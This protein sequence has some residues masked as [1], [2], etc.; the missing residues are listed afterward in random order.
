MC[1]GN[2]GNHV[3]GE[4]RDRE[5]FFDALDEAVERTGWLIHAYV[6]MGTHW[7]ALLETPEPNLSEGM[8]WFQ[9][10]FTQRY[11]SDHRT[12]GHVYQGRFKAIVVD[13]TDA[14]YFRTA[15][16]YIHLNP[17][18]AGLVHAGNRDLRT[19]EHSSYPYYLLPPSQRPKWLVTKRLMSAAHIGSDTAKSRR[20]Y[21]SYM[22]QR[23]DWAIAKGE[24]LKEHTEW[25]SLRRGWCHGG[26]EFKERMIV[27]LEEDRAEVLRQDNIGRQ[28]RDHGERGAEL[29]LRE[30]LVF[31]DVEESALAD[32][33][34][35]DPRKM[36]LAGILKA[37]FAVSNEWISQHLVMGHR[38][39]VTR[40]MRLMHEAKGERK[41]QYER[42]RR[43]LK[44]ST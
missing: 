5:I 12:W 4:A 16:E 9:Q 35:S 30:G 15:G 33:R 14:D 8:K 24:K 43:I 3:F 32:L 10:T 44:I 38:T 29:T 11:N 6:L 17:V 27:R 22:K 39:T 41:E 18:E 34:K 28:R 37:H 42:F 23:T 1:R 2:R 40:A 19:Y 36:F 21:E 25:Q 31:L 20:A 7:H 13:D 26:E